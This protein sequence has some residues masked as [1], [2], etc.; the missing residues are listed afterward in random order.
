MVMEKKPV[1]I[2]K[3][4]GERELFERRKLE[5]SLRKAGTDSKTIARIVN[6]I[7][8]E[9]TD[10][11]TTA[12][13]YRKAFQMLDQAEIIPATKYSV[14][15]AVMQLG[16]D[17]F[18]FEDFIGALYRARGYRTRLRQTIRG[19]CVPYEVDLIAENNEEFILGEIK[20]HNRQ[21]LKSD[22]KVVLYVK[23]RFD[24]LERGEFWQNIDKNLRKEKVLITN[25]KF[26]SQARMYAECYRSLH[27]ISWNYPENNNLHQMIIE[28]G[29]YPI[30][31]LK[32]LDEFEKKLFLA[33]K[34]V[35]CRE[36]RQGGERLFRLVGI[37]PEKTQETLAEINK[38][39]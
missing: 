21:G 8:I 38:I 27:L 24:D 19:L 23:A 10:G 3:A 18:P 17:G 26:T 31:C 15:K 34:V 30:T 33:K 29:L 11:M 1:Y 20:F 5:N 16:P 25:T 36:L 13:I 28:A 39:I 37:S 2:I 6:A 35:L 4:N 32:T 9:L 14:R 12:D 22:L 7:S